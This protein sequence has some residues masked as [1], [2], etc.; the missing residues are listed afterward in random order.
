[1]PTDEGLIHY[2]LVIIL[3]HRY[4][5]KKTSLIIKSWPSG[6][7]IYFWHPEIL[8]T[9]SFSSISFLF[10]E[11]NSRAVGK[12][13]IIKPKKQNAVNVVAVI[14]MVNPMQLE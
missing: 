10:V 8:L 14:L 4:A 7:E 1:M 11:N 5:S 12:Y 3:I 6:D 2:D 13:H 9:F